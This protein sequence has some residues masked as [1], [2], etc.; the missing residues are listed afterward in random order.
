MSATPPLD[1]PFRQIRLSQ[2]W[3]DLLSPVDA[4]V[5]YSEILREGAR[6]RT[7]HLLP[8]CERIVSA[9][10][11]LSGQVEQLIAAQAGGGS[12]GERQAQSFEQEWR[13]DLRT[14]L[15][16]V[17]GFGEILLEDLAGEQD[18]S[19]R[20]DLDRLLASTADLLSR[21]D[22]IVGCPAARSATG[23]GDSEEPTT[24]PAGLIQ[25]LR[26]DRDQPSVAAA[27]A[28]VLIVDDI[29]ANRDVLSRRL[30]RDG[31]RVATASGGLD[32][33]TALASTEFDLV[34]L[35][36]MMPDI[37]G[38]DV[39]LRM[40]ADER[41]RSVPVIMITG[42]TETASAIRCIEAGAEDYLPKPF[43]PVLLQARIHACIEKKRWRDRERQYLLRLEHETAR[44]ERLLL[45]VLPKQVIGRLSNGE[46]LI[47]DRYGEVTVLFA[48]LVGFTEFSARTAP[49]DVVEFL[50]RL[51]TEFDALALHLGVE[52]IKTIG[53]A[54]MAVAGLPDLRRDHRQA[55]ALLALNMVGGLE[56]VN[57]AL[58]REMKVRIGVHCGPVVAGIVGT[59]R[60]VYDVWGD[61]VNVASR[62]EA[63]AL[64]NHILISAD[65][66]QHLADD[67]VL[68]PH[69][70]IE[71]KGRGQMD[72][73]ILAGCRAGL[74][75]GVFQGRGGCA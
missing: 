57:E 5:A 61:T 50:R 17:K 8:D 51:F 64:P 18:D 54:Y 26:P 71:L 58:G 35:D 7:P 27:P 32:A 16:A 62:L 36:L 40:K 68:E 48:D 29:E 33:L 59:H 38:L 49:T 60:S 6:S 70:Q 75:P 74:A 14:P 19:V 11:N 45:S 31:Y 2:I 4:L 53:D 22:Q 37:N 39:L 65:A 42:L 15:N 12:P 23:G 13:H 9:A 72:T 47:A 66:A 43:N 67:F 41:L 3:Q 46:T 34:L 20:R 44:F 21:L 55:I 63:N 28:Y 56:R 73:F 1:E 52:K 24:M 10:R 69:G 30:T 25:T